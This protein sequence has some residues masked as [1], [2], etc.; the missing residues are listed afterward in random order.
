MMRRPAEVM[1]RALLQIFPRGF[2]ATHGDGMTAEFMRQYD[3][4]TGLRRRLAL[5]IRVIADTV[6]HGVGVRREFTRPG[7]RRWTGLLGA[8]RLDLRDAIRGLRR[9]PGITAAVLLIL[10]LGVAANSVMVGTIDQLLLRAPAGVGRPD[11]VR[12]VYFGNEQRRPGDLRGVPRVS[13]PFV[14]AVRDNVPAFDQAA[15]T[16]RAETTLG[17]GIHARQ[18][19]V[20]LVDAAYFSLLGLQPSIGRFFTDAESSGPDLVPAVVLSYGFW[21]NHFGADASVLGRPLN[22][23]GQMLTV[24]GVGPRGF[25]GLEDEAADMW[26]PLPVLAPT[27]VGSSWATSP[28]RFVF[29]L[30]ARVTPGVDPAMVDEQATTAVRNVATEL[31]TAPED[32]IAFAAPLARVAAPNGILPQ[33]RV[34]LWLL[35]VSAIVL[36]ISVAN[37]AGLLLTR[38]LAR[39]RE[40]AV[41]LALGVSRRR[42]IRQ[43]LTESALLAGGAVVLALF[44]AS[45]GGQLVQSLLLP[46][47]AWSESVV[48]L[49][50]FLTTLAIGVATAIGTGMA[51]AFQGLSTDPAAALRT[52]GR[53]GQARVGV[54]RTMLLF[55]QVALCV[56]LLVGAGLFTRSL[57][58]VLSKDVGLDLDEIVQVR[59]PRSPGQSVDAVDANYAAVASMVAQVPGVRSVVVSRGSA[60][61]SWSAAVSTRPEG[62]KL[63]ALNGRAMPA[64]FGVDERYFSTLGMRVVRG[65]GFTSDEVQSGAAVLVANRAFT[66]EFFPGVEPIGQCVIVGSGSCVKVVGVVDNSLVYSRTEVQDTQVFL[67]SSHP[68]ARGHQPSALLARTDGPASAVVARVRDVVQAASPDMPF[69]PVDDLGTLT[70]PQLQPWRLG[71]TM[72]L[73]FGGIAL[74]IAVVGIYSAMAHAVAQRTHE[75]GIRLALGASRGRV[76]LQVSRSAAFVVIAGMVGGLLGAIGVAPQIADLLFETP[77]REP[78]VYVVAGLVLVLAG[79][80]AA[81]APIRRSAAVDPLTTLRAE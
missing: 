57:M 68:A 67:P 53:D 46:G 1:Y 48:D 31:P 55:V 12:R 10:T 65:R 7:I 80:V 69:V 3:A 38:T 47:F 64:L 8:W 23:A 16:H 73:L 25:L 56:V 74:L 45:V 76:I 11:Q 34:S 20:D 44:V 40:I 27:M 77:P 79:G 36:L 24:I 39:R 22:V 2:R 35:G 66:E 75:I 26:T 81:I 43:F 54:V 19:A 72:F 42:L 41:R 78:L 4:L 17:A 18:V 9:T 60:P 29:G 52:D 21:Q 28:G 71:M 37:V 58:A 63:S 51:P 49:P 6:W 62:W 15:V 30:V 5:W 59:L 32:G 33:G 50:V 61:L 14:S 13:Y 70:A